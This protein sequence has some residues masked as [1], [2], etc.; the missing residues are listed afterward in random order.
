MLKIAAVAIVFFLLAKLARRIHRGFLRWL[1]MALAIF[2]SS[3]A[4][5]FAIAALIGFKM[6]NYPGS[7]PLG[8][9]QKIVAT[10]ARL[11]RGKQ[12]GAIC[13][14]CHSARLDGP[15]AGRN[16]FED[17]GP[18]IGTLYA[19]NLTPAG[20]ISEWSDAEVVRAIREGIHKSGRALAIMPSAV[21]HN[22]SDEDASSIV[23][24]LRSLKA[25]GARSPATKMNVVG[26]LFFG[27]GMFPT[28]AQPLIAQPVIAPPPA[29]NAEYGRYLISSGNCTECH[30]QDL[31][32][33]APK[34]PGPPA[35]PNMVAIVSSWDMEGFVN[36]FRSGVD[37]TNHRI[38]GE[39]PWQAISRFASDNDLRAMYTYLRTLKPYRAAAKKSES[40]VT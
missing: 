30:G 9:N 16:F 37:P 13:G 32:G 2:F 27:L 12:I 10:P 26:A 7:H 40:P 29:P 8:S 34:G 39:M 25:E 19:P 14:E 38:T 35:A 4:V 3:I 23:A 36:T 5:V 28:S 18:P 11:A 6:I 33:R 1:A 31:R 15:L 24:Y 22:M 21:F 17:G 20:E